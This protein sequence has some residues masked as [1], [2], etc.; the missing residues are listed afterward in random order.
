MAD[1][2]SSPLISIKS[3]NR[4][5]PTAPLSETITTALSIL[6][7]SV[8]RFAPCSATWFFDAE[9]FAHARDPELFR[10]LELSFRETLSRWPHWSGQLRWAAKAD[11]QNN[12]MPYGRP[13]ITYGRGKDVGV[14]WIIASCDSNLESIVPSRDARSTTDKVWMATKLPHQLQA[15]S[16]L[17]FSNLAEFDGLPG[18][19]V[20]LTAFECGG[21]SVNVKIA[22]CLS[23]AHS[24]LTF[25]HD[26]AAQSRV[27]QPV[28]TQPVFNPTMLDMHAGPLNMEHPDRQMVSRAREL[29]MH[30]FDWWASD[31][32][33]YP[34]WA[35]ASSVATM[36]P[37][38]V[39]KMQQLSSSTHPPWPTWNLALPVEHAQIRF[40]A[41]E[42]G[43]MKDAA[44]AS[45][46]PELSKHNI[47]RLDSLLSHVW[48][49]INRARGHESSEE[50]VYLN[51][52]LG[53]RARLS[54]PLPNG[55]VGSPILLTYVAKS[56]ADASAGSIGQIAA[57]IRSNLSQF[58]PEAISAYLH[59]AAYELSPQRLWQAFLGSQHTIVTSWTQMKAYEIR[60]GRVA[61]GGPPQ[62]ARYV[63]GVMP[64]LDGIVQVMD[65]GDSG[66]FDIS[67]NLES[68]AMRRLLEDPQLRA[69]A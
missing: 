5:S 44:M 16:K 63:Q 56:G 4:I 22:H 10:G 14:D 67:L 30:R 53:L 58:T 36:P 69:F 3:R 41:A 55:F 2:I 15:A 31:A 35:L 42:V 1:K 8:A 11:R 19:A 28:S 45:L 47:S 29:P 6:D 68:N 51:M 52:T 50:N 61:D 23:D 20:Q 21:W 34:D 17:A 39:L 59:D 46:P 25:M 38:D 66:D 32:P 48:M 7:A 54:P 49:L 24:L 12:Q 43:R 62:L 27:P 57:A 40:T 64:C 9:P 33:G 60:F 13:V 65:I 18:V 26:W 37:P